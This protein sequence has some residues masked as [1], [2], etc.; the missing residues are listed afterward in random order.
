MSRLQA[1]S[2]ITGDVIDLGPEN[3]SPA[4]QLQLGEMMAT[5]RE[6]SLIVFVNELQK[7][8]DE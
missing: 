3:E 4:A 7:W 5:G 6:N 1:Y 8:E 2:Q